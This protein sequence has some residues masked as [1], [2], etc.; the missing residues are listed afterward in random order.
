MVGRHWSKD[1]LSAWSPV[2]LVTGHPVFICPWLSEVSHLRMVFPCKNQAFLKC[3]EPEKICIFWYP[4]LQTRM[5]QAV[6]RITVPS[7][8]AFNRVMRDSGSFFCKAFTPVFLEKHWQ[9]CCCEPGQMGQVVLHEY[10]V[11]YWIVKCQQLVCP[12]MYPLKN[13]LTQ[14]TLS[15][16]VLLKLCLFLS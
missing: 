12:L 4:C 5:I 10:G 7:Y 1:A 9:T 15:N 16:D 11:R 13:Q 3:G 6:V 14:W 2:L 8:F